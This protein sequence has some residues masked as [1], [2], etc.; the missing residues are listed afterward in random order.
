MVISFIFVFIFT[1]V[2]FRKKNKMRERGVA[3]LT[4]L[5]ELLTI[6]DRHEN[7]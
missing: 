6:S 7:R 2:F 4:N 3:V 5:L 1:F